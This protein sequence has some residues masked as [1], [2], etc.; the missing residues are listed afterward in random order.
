MSC[1]ERT[2]KMSCG[3]QPGNICC[4]RE[5]QLLPGVPGAVRSS[6][7]LC[8]SRARA[9]EKAA[10]RASLGG[11]QPVLAALQLPCSGVSGNGDYR[12]NLMGTWSSSQGTSG[13]VTAP[14]APVVTQK[15][16]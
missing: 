16:S 6:S 2:P 15:P 8:Q 3:H 14:T 7:R 4:W 12:A 11:P 9:T 10:T 5:A 13:R 1:S